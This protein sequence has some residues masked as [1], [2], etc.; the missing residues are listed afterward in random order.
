MIRTIVSIIVTLGCIVTLSVYEI[1]YV[2][3]TFA[4][5]SEVLQSFYEKTE[6]QTVTDEDGQAL[7]AYWAEKKKTMHV[8]IPHTTLQEVD[9]RMNEA[10]GY[11]YLDNYEDALPPIEVLIGIAKNIPRAYTLKFE[12]VF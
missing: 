4:Y 11:I 10:I 8:W 2:H 5:F 12:N 1:Y 6:R 3:S 7:R 9:Y